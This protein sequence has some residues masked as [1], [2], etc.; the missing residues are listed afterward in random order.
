MWKKSE[1]YDQ[2][3]N[4]YQD[5][6]QQKSLPNKHLTHKYTCIQIIFMFFSILLSLQ[7]IVFVCLGG[8]VHLSVPPGHRRVPGSV[9]ILSVQAFL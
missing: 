7:W 4:K 8:G 1:I 2:Q 9:G 5:Q 3:L 6:Y